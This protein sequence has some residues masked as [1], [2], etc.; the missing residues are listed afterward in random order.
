MCRL[1][2][3]IRL[4]S[5]FTVAVRWHRNVLSKVQVKAMFDRRSTV[6]HKSHLLT[7]PLPVSSRKDPG[8]IRLTTSG[9]ANFSRFSRKL[10]YDDTKLEVSLFCVNPVQ[11][12]RYTLTHT[13]GTG[14]NFRCNTY[15]SE[16]QHFIAWFSIMANF[17]LGWAL[18]S[19]IIEFIN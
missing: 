5:M 9:V 12:H 17:L 10:S 13:Q 16:L 7:P 2:T 1:E 15:V 6:A 3:D 11:T 8:L 18:L 19:C 14:I 4:F